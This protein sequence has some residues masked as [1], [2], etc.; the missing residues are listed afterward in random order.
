MHGTHTLLVDFGA[1]RVKSAL[2]SNIQQQVVAVRECPA[3]LPRFGSAGEV[4]FDPQEYWNAFEETCGDLIETDAGVDCLWICTEM[5]G[6]L[7]ASDTGFAVSPYIS[8]RD[9][10]A[11][12]STSGGISTLD[13]LSGCEE[14]FFATTGMKLKAGL[15]F[16]TVAHL[17]QARQLPD[18]FRLCT[19]V[20]WLLLRG[21]ELDPGIHAS[22]AAGTGF[23]DI[24]AQAWSTRLMQE[25]GLE[26][27]ATRVPRVVKT[28]Q[29]LGEIVLRGRR[30]R[31]FGGL[32]DLQ[33]AVHG[34]G[35][36][37][38]A[39]LVVN[40]GTGS[41]VLGLSRV[42]ASGVERR[43]GLKNEHFAAITHI[44]SGRAL[45]VFSEFLDE[46]ALAGGG[47]PFFWQ[48]FAA[49][50]AT[51][52][53]GATLSVDLNI[54]ES[55][56]R[57]RSGGGI[58]GIRESSLSSAS[59][60][61]SLAKSWLTQYAQAMDVIDPGRNSAA[62]L[63][64]GGLSRRAAFILPV[65]EKLTGRHGLTAVTRTGEETLDG[66]LALSRNDADAD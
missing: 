57:F 4:E 65:L 31:V 33:A 50:E 40:L 38:Q 42:A 28:G 18:S 35:F 7:L 3:P 54:F 10:R 8:W 45:R 14:F 23:F 32:G 59:L 62:F 29:L 16:L 53:L 9:E 60:M 6:V 27:Y 11:G 63:L 47:A 44:P 30:I 49:L 22:L 15:P 55:A 34:V 61:A 51:D 19:L 41:Q 17:R 1:S 36:P 25:A 43:P 24:G 39:K 48:R 20:D 2:W 46:C 52:V 5:H 66:L 56:W 37:L 58:H 64:S 21:G 26:R 13:Q 12:R